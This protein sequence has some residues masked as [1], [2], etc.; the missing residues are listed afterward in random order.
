MVF[1]GF[2]L[3]IIILLSFLRISIEKLTYN[4][5]SR[6]EKMYIAEKLKETHIRMLRV[7]IFDGFTHG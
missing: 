2:M 1:S 3:S 4:I 6:G 7:A 5:T